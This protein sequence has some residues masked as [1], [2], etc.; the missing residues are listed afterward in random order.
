MIKTIK[1]FQ[2]KLTPFNTTKDWAMST[3][4]NQDLLLMNDPSVDPEEE[5]IA[6]EF[7]DYGNV[8]D[9]PI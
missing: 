6:L 3:T 7:I 9:F 5:P 8:D 2:I 1:K 4:N